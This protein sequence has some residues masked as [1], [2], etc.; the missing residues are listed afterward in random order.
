MKFTGKDVALVK[1]EIKSITDKLGDKAGRW[2]LNALVGEA[3]KN[4]S[5]V[6][7]DFM[8]PTK[9]VN[10][11]TEP[12][13]SDE[14]K[15]L[16]QDAWNRLRIEDQ[17]RLEEE[18]SE[19][20]SRFDLYSQIGGFTYRNKALEKMT[21]TR[22]RKEADDAESRLNA[23]RFYGGSDNNGKSRLS[24][25]RSQLKYYVAAFAA[26][27]KKDEIKVKF[28]EAI[29]FAEAEFAGKT[30]KEIYSYTLESAGLR[31][32]GNAKELIAAKNKKLLEEFDA[33][34]GNKT[35]DIPDAEESGEI[36][37]ESAEDIQEQIEALEEEKKTA[38]KA[39]K[40]EIES[41]VAELKE[42]LSEFED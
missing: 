38:T 5:D 2:L 30:E 8:V 4:L 25:F 16:V 7:A 11:Y 36:E 20:E 19:E 28:D 22:T 42:R 9:E 3:L 23:I 21:S 6:R 32:R 34:G 41:E 37:E 39:R 40:K 13:P 26:R 10:G 12:N 1:K 15:A 35:F 24:T 33:E 27:G 18:G 29:K 31:P 14:Q 17:M